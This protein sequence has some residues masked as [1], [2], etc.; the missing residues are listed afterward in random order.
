MLE[1]NWSDLD[2]IVYPSKK[3][4]RAAALAELRE[5][6]EKAESYD[7]IQ[8]EIVYPSCQGF[9]IDWI[10]SEGEYDT[11]DEALAAAKEKRE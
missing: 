1:P 10:F 6:R 9:K 7:L 5:L 3:R 11:L 4:R 8:N 2:S